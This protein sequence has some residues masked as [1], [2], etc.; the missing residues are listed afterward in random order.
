MTKP[1]IIVGCTR[2]AIY[3][4][5]RPVSDRQATVPVCRRCMSEL[6]SVYNW[7]F[8]RTMT[9]EERNHANDQD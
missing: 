8:V 2:S 4:A 7:T 6:A 5:Q 9:E 3:W 1:C